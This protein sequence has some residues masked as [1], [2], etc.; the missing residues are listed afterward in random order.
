VVPHGGSKAPRV[1]D[2]EV[3]RSALREGAAPERA[4]LGPC[5][6]GGVIIA[7]RVGRRSCEAKATAGRD[8]LGGAAV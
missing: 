6:G 7:R 5:R 4:S 2:R 8:E 1:Q 3:T